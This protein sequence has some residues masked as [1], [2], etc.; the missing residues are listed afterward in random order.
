M[1]DMAIAIVA[2]ALLILLILVFAIFRRGKLNSSDFS[3][4]MLNTP[5]M[6]LL[7]SGVLILV[8][9]TIA[10]IAIAALNESREQTRQRAGESLRAVSTT[11]EAA[12]STWLGGWESR[13]ISIAADPALRAQIA[14]LAQKQPT[15]R[16]LEN[17][18]ELRTIREIIREFNSGLEYMGFFVISPDFVN[19][20][21]MRNSNLAQVNLIAEHYPELLE[22]TFK[23]ETVFIPSVRSD[24]PIPGITG[25]RD[26]HASMFIASPV[27][28]ADGKVIAV[29]AIRMDPALEFG[30]L[31]AGGRVGN[32]GETYFSNGQGYM[33][34]PSRFEQ[35]LLGSGTL[36]PGQ[37][38]IL[39]I[40][41]RPPAK[42]DETPPALQQEEE[43]ILTISAAGVRQHESGENFIGYLNYR[44][45]EV[46]GVWSWNT[47]LGFGVITEMNRNDAL[48]GY[49][50]SRNIILGVMGA[51]VPLCLFLALG[52]FS[53]SRK[54]TAQLVKANENLEQRV[55]QR[56]R[57][58][59]GRENRL[60]DLY[61]NA[62]VAYVSI[63]DHGAILKH[64]LAFSR[65][66][67]YPREEFADIQWEDLLAGQ[68][69]EITRS[70]IKGEPCMDLPLT[71]KRK[72]G[73]AVLTSAAAV[74]M[75]SDDQSLE[76]VRISLLDLTEREEAMR[77]LEDA[78]HLAEEANQMKSDFL[79]N[80]SHEI[81]TPMNAVIG[82][83]YLALKTDLDDKQRNY[84]EKVNSSAEALLGVVNDILDFSKIEAGKLTLEQIDFELGPVLDNLY[85]LVG[86]KAE[87]AGLNLLFDVAPD[88]PN[89][90]VGDPLRLGQIL[91][92]LGN[93]AVKFTDV[94]K[95]VVSIGVLEQS[96]DR[97][98]LQFDVSDTGI[99]MSE[100]QQT[101][102]F[103]P[104]SQADTSTTR[105]Y[106]GTGLGLA[107]CQE[108]THMM[109][110]DIWVKSNP[111]QGSVFSFTA[112]F[113]LQ[114]QSRQVSSYGLPVSSKTPTADSE[115][116]ESAAA[117]L[118]G[119]NVLLVEDN[120]LNQ[121]LAAELLTSRG[122]N[123]DIAANGKLALD[124]LEQQPYDGVLM[125]CQMPVLDGYSATRQL[126]KKPGFDDLPVIAM[127]A[128]AMAGDR[129]I[130]L[131]AG[132]NDH[133]PKPIDVRQM[134]TTIAKWISPS[135]P[136]RISIEPTAERPKIK[137]PEFE[138]VNTQE[139]LARLGG[140]H[141]LYLKLLQ[142][143]YLGYRDFNQQLEAT[144]KSP[145]RESLPYVI[146]TLKGLAGN[147]GATEVE[148]AARTMEEAMGSGEP[149]A[150]SVDVLN[151][152]ME[153]LLSQLEKLDDGQL[154]QQDQGDFDA[155]L[156]K[157]TLHKLSTMIAEYDTATMDFLQ[158]NKTLLSTPVLAQSLNILQQA[159]EEYDYDK[160]MEISS[161]MEATLDSV[162]KLSGV[163][164]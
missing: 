106:G 81:R 61:E 115:W 42:T 164:G 44:G 93:N 104:F 52:V 118:A 99:G 4:D 12:L 126:R 64:N 136:A 31:T 59:E 71:I 45:L 141:S 133:I 18:S 146:H 139:S 74:P 85:N 142:R 35:Q 21:S 155:A 28:S 87:E 163:V 5:Y 79:A 63:S 30:R 14:A 150:D 86:L 98:R 160:A 102:L 8:L 121:E 36:D 46:I 9:T 68:N 19:I 3:A 111:G 135:T 132:M 54:A 76:E 69:E 83:S 57:A 33:I 130:A 77:V 107:I 88:I 162:N 95:V 29:V 73:S 17:S 16:V 112:D 38:S 159:I 56:T 91:V 110:G 105:N 51:I 82:M 47:K 157:H 120:V 60:W 97:V 11:T 153:H 125:D 151:R 58:L 13:I 1:S 62:P 161:D 119:A 148:N 137:L 149:D 127:T 10:L 156:A 92:N 34:S 66:T 117:Q 70:I 128:N 2:T 50:G 123:V 113:G 6:R 145:T 96:E 78:K 108:M 101:L 27:H 48:E 55:Q 75:Y 15:S 53:I 147:I 129:E 109:G 131:A 65:L 103:Q 144:L 37:T 140:N 143:F 26:F 90:L 122:I 22:R 116:Y 20:G 100:E 23:G 94:G 41:I 158:Q 72:N 89:G 39:N 7:L 80:M 154:D 49:A 84:I 152:A 114:D 40:K 124:M 25:T 138:G 134:F 24:I 67:G 43:D 32:S